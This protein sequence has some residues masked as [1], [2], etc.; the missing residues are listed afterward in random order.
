MQEAQLRI[1]LHLM[2]PHFPTRWTTAI[3]PRADPDNTAPPL[4]DLTGNQ[5]HL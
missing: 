1:A 4:P 5:H 3:T 2:L